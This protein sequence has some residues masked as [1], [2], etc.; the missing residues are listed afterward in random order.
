MDKYEFNIKVEQMKKQVNKGDY[1]TAMKIADAIDWKRVRNTNLLS[2]VAQIYEKNEEYAEAKEILLLAFERAPIGKRLL[3]KLTEIALRENSITEAEAYYREF[4]DLAPDDSRQNLLRYMI[5]KAKGA[6]V[7]QLIHSLEEYVN[8]ELDEKWMYELAKLYQEANMPDQC[9]RVCDKIM[10]MFGLGKYVDKAM[11]LKIQYAPLTQYQ[12]DLVENRDKY[13]AKLRDV[14]RGIYRGREVM[15]EDYEPAAPETPAAPAAGADLVATI[16]EAEVEEKLAQEMSRI[17]RDEIE[18]REVPAEQTRVLGS[19][20]DIIVSDDVP[21]PERPTIVERPV[22]LEEAEKQAEAEVAAEPPS[23]ETIEAEIEVEEEP[24]TTVANHLMIEARTPEKGLEMAVKALKQIH[25]EM[26]EK[27][28][29]AKI[30][31]DKLNKKGIFASAE[32]L[33][34][35][36]LVI[37]NAGDLSEAMLGELN[38][39]MEQDTT[40]T[41]VVL[42]DNPRQM[43]QLHRQNPVLASKFEC[44]GAKE[45]P[46]TSEIQDVEQA[47][48]Q[49]V[50]QE[51]KNA[52]RMMEQPAPERRQPALAARTAGSPAARQSETKAK[53]PIQPSK[54]SDVSDKKPAKASMVKRRRRNQPKWTCRR[55]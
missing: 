37:E 16:H 28:P 2:M 43:E 34:G 21:E 4:C 31:G 51:E 17:S 30:S 19:I 13:E 40:G 55:N 3:Y 8:Q 45:E 49:Q 11:D 53:R 9:V 38:H 1:E 20:R 23:V 48:L 5:L 12:M 42:I 32:K 22:T 7:M 29:V 47:V 26:G 50:M 14:E 41:I 33:A 36:D 10:L 18:V 52:K 44:I 24:E 15:E 46:K 35:K 6:P 54:P 39:F 25:E 27:H